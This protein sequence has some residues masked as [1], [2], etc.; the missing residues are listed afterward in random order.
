MRREASIAV[1]EHGKSASQAKHLGRVNIFESILRNDSLSASEKSGNRIAQEG[2]EVMS[3]GGETTS[4]VLAAALFYVLAG[5]NSELSRLKE[6]LSTVVKDGSSRP[7][8]SALEQLPYLVSNN[9]K[10]HYRAL[11]VGE[12]S[13]HQRI[14][15]NYSAHKLQTSCGSASRE[16]SVWRMGD[17]SG[18]KCALQSFDTTQLER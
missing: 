3:A 9:A 16:P 4:R 5:K 13:S 1:H 14:I 15:E 6:E 10:P 11:T 12:D 2:F 17:P 18:S 8:W 7:S